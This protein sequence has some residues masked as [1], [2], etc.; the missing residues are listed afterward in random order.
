MYHLYC[1]MYQR[2]LKAV[3]KVLPWRQPELVEGE[4]SLSKL[5][6]LIKKN[7]VKNVLIVT[8]KGITKIG[9]MD[10]LLYELTSIG[11]KYV[12]YNKTV[13]N[14]TIDNIEEALM[15]YRANGCE[16]ILA[17]G[18]GSPMDCA[19]GVGARL[20]RPEKS[21]SEM[22]GQLKVR[23]AIPPLFAVPTTSGTGSEATLAAVIS[24]SKT[25]EK[26]AVLDTLLYWI[27]C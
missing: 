16:G 10:G 11:I 12:I 13:P 6:G 21:I 24:N 4:K 2:T 7:G 3:M 18:G 5:P 15:S 17:F 9:L 22:K 27:L 20:A 14:P 26:Y 23:K 1:R 19:K 8:D 25:H